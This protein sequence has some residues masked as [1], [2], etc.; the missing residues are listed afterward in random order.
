[1]FFNPPLHPSFRLISHFLYICCKID[2][3]KHK[4][5]PKASKKKNLISGE[6]EILVNQLDP[7]VN[8]EEQKVS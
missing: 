3:V 1:M 7:E 2:L 4:P 8:D 6:K 5:R